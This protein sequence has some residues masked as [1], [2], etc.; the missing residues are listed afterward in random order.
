MVIRYGSTEIIIVGIQEERPEFEK[1]G[2]E[3][4][5]IMRLI[6][7]V[8]LVFAM[9]VP[10]YAAN[11]SFA[12]NGTEFSVG[13]DAESVLDELGKASKVYQQNSVV[14]Q[15]KYTVYSYDEFELSIFPDGI[16]NVISDIYIP[17]GSSASTPE[18]L[19][20]GSTKD[21]M[22]RIYGSDF[23]KSGDICRYTRGDSC[24]LVYLKRDKVDRI[25]Y[26]LN[27]E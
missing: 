10:C 5:K 15:G 20:I 13:D 24:L 4:K 3:M 12:W 2:I 8:V 1:G 18:G 23:S 26:Q 16:G 6:L 9:A 19:K 25:E 22:V 11:F 14:A 27:A 7:A 17:A 21:D